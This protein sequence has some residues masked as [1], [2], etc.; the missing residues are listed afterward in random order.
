MVFCRIFREN[1]IRLRLVFFKN[2]LIKL[3]WQRYVAENEQ[4]VRDYLDSLKT[5]YPEQI[6]SQILLEDITNLSIG[7]NYEILSPQLF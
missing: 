1:S 7:T 6:H 4:E 2:Q 3:L 5:L